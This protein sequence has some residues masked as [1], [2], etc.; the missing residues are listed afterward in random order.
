MSGETHHAYLR[1]PG[2][3]PAGTSL[4]R[5]GELPPDGAKGFTFGGDVNRFEMF[6]VWRAG[7]LLAY[8][9]DCPHAH[10][11]L[12]YLPDRFFSLDKSHLLCGTHG[13]LFRIQNGLCAPHLK[14]FAVP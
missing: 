3:P 2:A 4:C 8:V 13:A 12:D 1:F 5:L 6:V 11:T 14:I 9:N 10:T 7:E